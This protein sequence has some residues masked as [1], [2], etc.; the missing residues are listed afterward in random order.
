MGTVWVISRLGSVYILSAYIL[1][2][3]IGAAWA[4]GY[5][6]YK[7]HRAKRRAELWRESDRLRM[8]WAEA[9]AAGDEAEA[10]RLDRLASQAF[11]RWCDYRP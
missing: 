9:R 2:G 11:K 3:V 10:R 6:V 7:G 8:A 1:G 5:A 4:I